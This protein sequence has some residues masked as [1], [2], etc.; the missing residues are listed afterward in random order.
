MLEIYG[1][2]K[3]GHI[4]GAAGRRPPR[5]PQSGTVKKWKIN[6]KRPRCTWW[7]RRSAIS[8]ISRRAA[9]TLAAVDFIAAEDARHGEA[10]KPLRHQKAACQLLR[11][12][13][14]GE[15][16]RVIADRMAAGET[17]ALV[18]DAGMP[19]ISDPG[20]DLVALCAARGIR[21]TSCPARARSFRRSRFRACR[22][23][24]YVRG[25]F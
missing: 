22:R 9:E 8:R 10:L 2:Y 7:A 5:Q 19:A 6:S 1:D 20:E 15:G 17:C 12:Q 3:T 18:S 25:A 14:A 24:A 11:A 4:T 23:A 21:C 16:Q 13:Q